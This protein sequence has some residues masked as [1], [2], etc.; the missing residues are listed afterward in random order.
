MTKLAEYTIIAERNNTFERVEIHSFNILHDVLK[1]EQKNG[2]FLLEQASHELN[3][4]KIQSFN[5]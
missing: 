3:A 2:K 1:T 5:R 4:N